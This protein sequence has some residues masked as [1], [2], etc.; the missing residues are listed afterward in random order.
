MTSPTTKTDLPSALTL[1]GL[2]ATA[3]TLD[4]FLARAT[5][6]RWTAPQILEELV[7]VEMDARAR[8]SL[9]RRLLRSRIG[10]FKPLADFDWNWPK[11]ID[12]SLVSLR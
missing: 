8:R 11:K 1:L 9:Q 7:R 2:H 6:S 12:R 5:R 4:D 3:A 10:S